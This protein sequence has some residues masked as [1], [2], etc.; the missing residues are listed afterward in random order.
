MRAFRT[1]RLALLGLAAL[2]AACAAPPPPP[3]TVALTI[4]ATPEMNDAAPARIQVYYLAS[5]AGFRGQDYFALSGDPK[6]AL[7]ADLVASDEYLLSPGQ[8]A[9]ESRSFDQPVSHVGVV[10]GFRDI[11]SAGWRAILPL[12][13][14]APNAVKITVGANAVSIGAGR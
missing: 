2:A 7:G 4:A 14:N 3:T 5:A 8:T 10:V 1:I 13:A 12:S 6:A 11:G 9:T